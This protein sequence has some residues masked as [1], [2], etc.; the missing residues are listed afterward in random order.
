MEGFIPDP[1][2]SGS[3]PA[4]DL[5]HNADSL[6]QQQQQQAHQ[7][8]FQQELAD[9]QHQ[10]HVNVPSDFYSA[11]STTQ[12]SQDPTS[13]SFTAQMSS[14]LYGLQPQPSDYSAFY[15]PQQ[16]VH[17]Q[18][19]LHVPDISFGTQTVGLQNQ[20]DPTTSSIISQP[21]FYSDQSQNQSHVPTAQVYQ[22]TPQPTDGSQYQLNQQYLHSYPTNI[23]YS[24]P[25]STVHSD[26]IPQEPV[27]TSHMQY[28]QTPSSYYLNGGQTAATTQAYTAPPMTSY[29]ST[30][31]LDSSNSIQMPLSTQQEASSS[32][33]L[34]TESVTKEVKKAVKRSANTDGTKPVKK[35]ASNKMGVQPDPLAGSDQSGK[36]SFSSAS[37]EDE[38]SEIP[39]MSVEDPVTELRL[40][41]A[42][43][44]RTLVNDLPGLLERLVEIMQSIPEEGY[45]YT[46]RMD[47]RDV[48]TTQILSLT[49]TGY[50][51]LWRGMGE[52][53]KCL[54]RI[55]NWLAYDYKNK[56]LDRSKGVLLALLRMQPSM[57]LLDVTKMTKVLKFFAS[58]AEAPSND[59]AKRILDKAKSIQPATKKSSN[60][61]VVRPEKVEKAE[62]KLLPVSKSVTASSSA[63]A[64]SQFGR[65]A[66]SNFTIPKRSSAASSAASSSGS[67]TAPSSAGASDETSGSTAA[68]TKQVERPV[69]NATFFQGLARKATSATPANPVPEVKPEPAAP[70]MP[71]AP[72]ISS[73]VSSLRGNTRSASPVAVTETPVAESRSRKQKKKVSWKS[74]SDLVQVRYFESDQNSSK[75]HD[76]QEARQL[77]WSEWRQSRTS[78]RST[79]DEDEEVESERTL[80]LDWYAPLGIDFTKS[81]I[82]LREQNRN[83]Y[84]RGGVLLADSPE[85]VLQKEREE[86]VLMALSLPRDEMP[87][88]ALEPIQEED[89][90]AEVGLPTIIPIP[91]KLKNAWSA[92]LETA[93]SNSKRSA[94]TETLNQT[95]QLIQSLLPILKA[96]PGTIPPPAMP[97]QPSFASQTPTLIPQQQRDLSAL[98]A[99]M[100]SFAASASSAR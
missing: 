30:L 58:K 17:S 85:A 33:S 41:I 39:L 70:V 12:S 48:F 6:Q 36:E 51:D 44:F 10:Y 87:A 83:S 99:L 31:K 80:V 42:T 69:G 78:G 4:D 40:R 89:Q 37:S 55:R 52:N 64:T 86:S 9:Q 23:Q 34:P 27:N 97:I 53:I 20:T 13:G 72:R 71:T 66:L 16:Q 3:M 46:F 38:S 81:E 93:D 26:S 94:D 95:W 18:Q 50:K 98:M 76:L 88:S 7:L 96:R 43:A 92:R 5:P 32:I 79:T 59:F 67:T 74:D 65:G 8:Q 35:R 11:Y 62:A 49:G 57:A 28:V 25:G 1:T 82:P 75:T 63:T 77:D 29:M 14:G 68:V 73:I 2:A 47:L 61:T 21:G 84:K 15:S 19:E 22:Y 90:E 56:A 60:N 100:G 24:Y 45:G 54:A 91:K